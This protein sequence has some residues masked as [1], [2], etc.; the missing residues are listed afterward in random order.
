[1]GTRTLDQ[2]GTLPAKVLAC[3]VCH[4]K[5]TLDLDALT[6]ANGHLY[7]AANGY[8]D[9]WPEDQPQPTLDWFSTPYGLFYDT[10]IKER[11]LA[12]VGAR[13]G[14]G[15]DIDRMYDLMD[16]GIKC[17]TG[18]VILDVPVGGAPPLRSAPGRMMGTYVGVDLS[19]SMLQRARSERDAEGIDN[20][21]LARGDATRLPLGDESV[22]RILCF[23]GLHVLPDKEAAMREFARVLKPGGQLWGNVVIAD[24]SAIARLTRPWF[25]WPWAF[26]HPADPVDLELL[27]VENG[28]DWD[29]ETEGSMLFFRGTRLS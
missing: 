23:N 25:S 15:T 12:R 28:F 21:V 5:L 20:V 2:A 9:M 19:P 13:F 14:F 27:A 1:M 8:F 10:G 3:P 11:W 29:Q 4:D 6:C 26:F 7:L 17:A 16:D 22:H 18:E 24:V